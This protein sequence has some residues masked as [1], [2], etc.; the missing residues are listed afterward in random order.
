MEKY[1]QQFSLTFRTLF[2]C[3]ESQNSLKI[4]LKNPDS[5]GNI[6]SLNKGLLLRDDEVISFLT[7]WTTKAMS[8]CSDTTYRCFGFILRGASV[9]GKFT[10]FLRRR[11]FVLLNIIFPLSHTW[12]VCTYLN[13][14]LL[15]I[16]N[17]VMK[18]PKC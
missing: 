15:V 18:I 2:Q 16:P 10:L 14:F 6:N 1:A 4:I 13:A 8:P 11:V 17:M 5:Y 9:Q 7:K 12:H 3:C